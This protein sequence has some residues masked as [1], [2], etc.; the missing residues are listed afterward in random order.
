M[1]KELKGVVGIQEHQ[2]RAG[3]F[4]ENEV[5]LNMLLRGEQAS[6]TELA[7]F[8]APGGLLDTWGAS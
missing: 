7:W 2:K 6:L 3:V 5:Y 1:N 4:G 8:L